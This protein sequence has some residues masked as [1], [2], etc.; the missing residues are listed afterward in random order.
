MIKGIFIIIAFELLLPVIAGL[1]FAAFGDRKSRFSFIASA[2]CH[3][4]VLLFALFQPL[5]VYSILKHLHFSAMMKKYLILAAVLVIIC[6]VIFNFMY[7][8]KKDIIRKKSYSDKISVW[9]ILA[10]LAFAFMIVMSFFMTYADGDDAY[11]VATSVVT[12]ASDL[13][14]V[15]DPYTGLEMLAPYRYLFAPF[16]VWIT[17]LIRLSGIKGAVVAHTLFPWSMILL[18]VLTLYLLS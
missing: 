2:L 9:G 6:A 14:Y 3:G 10:C 17:M 16:S 18:S 11:Y 4:Q 8:R 7:K 15:V 5:C 13:M 1:P 12:D